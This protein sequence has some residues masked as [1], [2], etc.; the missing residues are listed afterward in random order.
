MVSLV[1]A[2]EVSVVLVVGVDVTV[3]VADEVTVLVADVVTVVVVSSRIT[4][5][6]STPFAVNVKISLPSS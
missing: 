5:D 2:V 4:G 6:T 3:N 1:V